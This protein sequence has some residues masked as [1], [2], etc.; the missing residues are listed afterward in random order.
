MLLAAAAAAGD[1]SGQYVD[2]T[3]GQMR[4]SLEHDDDGS[5]IGELT[6]AY[7]TLELDGEV[8]GDGV[9]GE[10]IADWVELRFRVTRRDDGSVL[11]ELM[12]GEDAP[13]DATAESI[14]FVPAAS[15]APEAAIA[16]TQSGAREVVINGVRLDDAKVGALETQYGIPIQSGR[17]W[18]DAACGAWGI[19]GGPTAGFI[20]AGLDLPGPMPAGISGGGTNIFINGR[21]IHQQ[22]QVALQNIFGY[23]IPGRYWLDAQGNLGPEGGAAITNLAMAMQAAR[24]SQS[25]GSVTHGYGKAYGAR[26]TLAGGMYSGRTA[27]GKSVLWYPGM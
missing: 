25:G 5:V 12:P 27:S 16:D 22:D 24:E 21:E 15:S 14:V 2:A 11:F 13:A 23:T 20:V 4:L 7:T 3:E 26:G 1:F 17:Y 10:A 19:E 8:V 18:Y 6:D 9:R